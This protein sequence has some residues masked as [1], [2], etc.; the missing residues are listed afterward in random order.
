M[1]SVC[2]SLWTARVPVNLEES[3]R[4]NA[5]SPA[6]LTGEQGSVEQHSLREQ[7]AADRYPA[8]SERCVWLWT[9]RRGC[10]CPGGKHCREWSVDVNGA[11]ALWPRKRR[12]VWSRRS[13]LVVRPARSVA[14]PLCAGLPTSHHQLQWGRGFEAA[15]TSA[16]RRRLGH[17]AP[18]FNGAAALRP[19]KRR[20]VRLPSR[21]DRRAS[22]GPRL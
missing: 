21:F 3:I 9:G 14:A 20:H 12:R 17:H 15:E 7:I 10:D 22:M 2:L 4:E 19:R 5:T 6:K 1:R 16:G 8:V 13:S 18:R 11:A